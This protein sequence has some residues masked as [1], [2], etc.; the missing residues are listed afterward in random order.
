MGVY[1]EFHSLIYKIINTISSGGIGEIVKFSKREIDKR[2][3]IEA[4][5]KSETDRDMLS[6]VLQ[7]HEAN[8]QRFTMSDIISICVTNI[9]AGS[10]TTSISLTSILYHLMRSP[11]CLEKVRP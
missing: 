6:E 3:L 4:Q 11:F 8:P 9:G 2:L 5:G 10:D 1:S 7:L